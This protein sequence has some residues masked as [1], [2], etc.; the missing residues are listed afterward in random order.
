MN[1]HHDQLVELLVE[2]CLPVEH[3]VALV[4][5]LTVLGLKSL[6]VDRVALLVHLL[7]HR[8]LLIVVIVLLADL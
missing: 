1:F 3:N 4:E 5:K 2:E 8:G 6:E 7:K